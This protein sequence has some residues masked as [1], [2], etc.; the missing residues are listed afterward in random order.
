MCCYRS[1]KKQ[2][3]FGVFVDNGREDTNIDAIEWLKQ[4]QDLG[5]GEILVTSVDYE[6]VK[7]GINKNLIEEIHKLLEFL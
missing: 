7:K 3:G 4:V 1:N 5:A 6:G 2:N